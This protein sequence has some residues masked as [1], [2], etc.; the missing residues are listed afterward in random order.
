MTGT[1]RAG[2]Y[3]NRWVTFPQD[4]PSGGRLRMAGVVNCYLILEGNR[5]A[6]DLA[7]VLKRWQDAGIEL[8]EATERF[9]TPLTIKPPPLYRSLY[10]RWLACEPQTELV[11]RFRRRFPRSRAAAISAGL[12]ERSARA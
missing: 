3:D 5:V 6:D 10:Y 4:F 1:P 11:R 9:A 7:H 12:A 8:F 2:H